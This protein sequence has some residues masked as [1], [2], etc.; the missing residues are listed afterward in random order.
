MDDVIRQLRTALLTSDLSYD[1][2]WKRC[3]VSAGTLTA[4]VHGRVT[5]RRR[6]ITRLARG[7]GYVLIEDGDGWRLART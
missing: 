5:P 4:L 2:I 6:T 7:L 3:G 1:D